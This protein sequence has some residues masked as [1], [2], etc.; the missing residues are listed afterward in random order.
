[1]WLYS[2]F[3][4]IHENLGTFRSHHRTVKI[5]PKIALTTYKLVR[6]WNFGSSFYSYCSW[7]IRRVPNGIGPGIFFWGG[8]GWNIGKNRRVGYQFICFLH[9]ESIKMKF[10]AIGP[11]VEGFLFFLFLKIYPTLTT[12]ASYLKKNFCTGHFLIK[13]FAN[14]SKKI[15]FSND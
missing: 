14:I 9:A 13:F 8:E 3:F 5:V 4:D 12:C 2:T 1:M 15:E 7:R 10:K 11:I 6:S